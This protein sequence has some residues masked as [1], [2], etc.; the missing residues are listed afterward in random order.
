MHLR[1]HK[2]ISL[3]I[4]APQQ[5]ALMSSSNFSY[6]NLT[7]IIVLLVFLLLQVRGAWKLYRRIL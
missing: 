7:D 1:L 5:N 6:P 2:N 3:V 4:E